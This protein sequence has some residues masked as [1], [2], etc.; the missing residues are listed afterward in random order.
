M[1]VDVEVAACRHRTENVTVGV[2]GIMWRLVDLQPD[3]ENVALLV[4]DVYKRL[5]LLAQ[6]PLTCQSTYSAVRAAATEPARA[7]T[8]P[9]TGSGSELLPSDPSNNLR[10][11]S[12]HLSLLVLRIVLT[13][14]S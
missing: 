5:T 9:P 10:D 13:L 14:Q 2:D 11:P 7:A 12:H 6:I 8:S 3:D 1:R 4:P